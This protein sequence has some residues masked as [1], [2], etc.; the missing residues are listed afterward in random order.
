MIINRLVLVVLITCSAAPSSAQIPDP[1]NVPFSFKG[2]SLGMTLQAFKASN[3]QGQVWVA[4]GPA[5]SQGKAK[6]ENKKQVPT[7]LCTDDYPSLANGW[8]ALSPGEVFCNPAPGETNPEARTV[9][10]FVLPGIGYYFYNDK[11]YKIDMHFAARH[12]TVIRAAFKDKY[13]SQPDRIETSFQNG[14]GAHW[15]GESLFWKQGTQTVLLYEGS[16]NGPGQ[17]R[18]SDIGSSTATFSDNAFVPP[19][20]PRAKSDF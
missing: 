11:L 7:P 9:A 14:F 17:D 1:V 8:L 6:K 18:Y 10:G 4:W 16:M 2:N 15:I 3:N 13:G 5:N 20:K 12:Y 19:T